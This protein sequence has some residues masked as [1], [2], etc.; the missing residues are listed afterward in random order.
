[1]LRTE[2]NPYEY[3]YIGHIQNTTNNELKEKI[4]LMRILV[5]KLG[6]ILDNNKR[7]PIRDELYKLE[8]RRRFTKIQKEK[9]LIY[10]KELE[11][12]LGKKEKY[13]Y[14]DNYDLD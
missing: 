11:N 12:A 5:N 13:Q 3:N 1:M 2:I 8:K 10:L 9:A 4:N 14:N 6:D 7:K